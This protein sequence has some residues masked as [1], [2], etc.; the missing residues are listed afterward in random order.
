MN[1]DDENTL[2]K[3]PAGELA[4][5]LDMMLWNMSNPP[6][7]NEG[8]KWLAELLTRPDAETPEIQI[9]IKVMLDYLSPEKNRK[10]S[11]LPPTPY[12]PK[13]SVSCLPWIA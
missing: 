3:L 13:V 8:Q 11:F 4:D 2:T 9:A 1:S 12:R 5:V 6:G 7:Q 10:V